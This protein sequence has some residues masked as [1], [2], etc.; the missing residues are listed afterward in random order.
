MAMLFSDILED[1]RIQGIIPNKTA[2]A[3]EWYRSKAKEI[4]KT[5]E[6]IIFNDRTNKFENRFRIGHMYTF[7]YDPKHKADLPYYDRVPLIFPVDVA[8]GGFYGINFHYLPLK[9]RAKLMDSLYEIT[10]NKRY[11]EKTKLNI[12]YRLLKSTQSLS[13]FKPTFKHYL[14][15]Q[16]RSRLVYIPPEQWDVALFVDFARFEKATKTQVWEDSKEMI[17]NSNLKNPNIKSQSTRK[18]K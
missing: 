11:D 10:N 14:A 2:V 1:G 15:S 12:S 13:Y 17:K 5:Q 9:M 7:F 18:V 4:G 6:S 3:R 16:I 8:P